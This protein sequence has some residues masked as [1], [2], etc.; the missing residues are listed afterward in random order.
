MRKLYLGM[1]EETC[2]FRVAIDWEEE[3][4]LFRVGKEET[5]RWKRL[6]RMRERRKRKEGIWFI[7]N[8]KERR[9][10]HFQSI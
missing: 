7:L 6:R 4:C 3:T 10:C 1:V 5:K 9:E 2:F 8:L